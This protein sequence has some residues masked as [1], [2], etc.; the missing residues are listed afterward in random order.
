MGSLNRSHFFLGP[1]LHHVTRHGV[2]VGMATLVS[3]LVANRLLGWAIPGYVPLTL[4]LWL[5]TAVAWSRGTRYGL[6]ATG[7]GVVTET[8]LFNPS[9]P[10]A[11]VGPHYVRFVL[12]VAQ[13][14]VISLVFGELRRWQS[15]VKHHETE[16]TDALAREQ[17]VRREHETAMQELRISE[18]L[19]QQERE[20]ANNASKV[21][22][23]FLAHM[24]HEMRT[25][26]VAILGFADLL[27][28]GG[29]TEPQRRHYLEIIERTGGNLKLIIDDV[30]D[31]SK[32]EA[33]QFEMEPIAF[34]LGGV[35]DEIRS[36]FGHT[37]QE[38]GL[39]LILA[40]ADHV[41]LHIV[42]D[43]K[44]VRQ[45]LVNL[46]GNAV[47]FTSH[48]H[49]RLHVRLEGLLLIFRIEDTGAGI[50]EDHRKRLFQNFGQGDNSVSRRF[51]GAGL[52]L[53]LS[54]KFALLMGGDIRLVSTRPGAGAVFEAS[55]EFHPAEGEAPAR[56][57][58][59]DLAPP[60]CV[61]KKVLVVDDA[62]DNRVLLSVILNKL[63][64]QVT[65]ANN[66]VEA[67]MKVQDDSFDIIFMDM[68]MPV[69]D[70]YTAAR[71]L[72]H[73]GSLVPVVALTAH[74]LKEDRLKCL[75]AG[76]DEY[77]T[78]PLDKAQLYSVIKAY[79]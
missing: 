12:Y 28:D 57:A 17:Q 27:K 26:L 3:I 54:R 71:M 58:P 10:V 9:F 23:L 60:V 72:R 4:V 62:K 79:C 59:M 1:G 2:L 11:T 5:V 30:L 7:L 19:L 31:L 25:P 49:V 47:K 56:V 51:G 39:Q 77:L 18:E 69:M 32:V 16:L 29:L 64:L 76:C 50:S 14:V 34:D 55:I 22:N 43:P 67:L 44:R 65:T 35:L 33:G 37:C 41:P 38:K 61:G 8:V 63:G 45:V 70:G 42:A 66:G 78:K 53:A 21:K 24:S 20:V 48:G 68:Q 75:E 73:K 6:L 15:A 36:L 46:V 13:G 52:G 74:A 40:V